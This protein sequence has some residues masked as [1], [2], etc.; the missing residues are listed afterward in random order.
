VDSIALDSVVVSFERFHDLEN[1]FWNLQ[2]GQLDD[3][4]E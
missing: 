1:V 3:V 4:A 2:L